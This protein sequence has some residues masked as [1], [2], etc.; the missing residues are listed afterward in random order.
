VYRF[1]HSIGKTPGLRVRGDRTVGSPTFFIY[2]NNG[3]K[4][5]KERIMTQKK[6]LLGPALVLTA[7]IVFAGCLGK[8]SDNEKDFKVRPIEGGKGVEITEYVGDKFEVRIPPR[9]QKLP[10]TSIGDKAFADKSITSVTIPSSVK[11]IG[12]EAFYRCT[13]L[14][15][16][17]IPNGVTS[18]GVMAFAL[19]S[20][21]NITIPD[22]VT[23]MGGSAFRSCSSLTNAII[24]NGIT[25]IDN[26]EYNH[27][28]NWG[29]FEYCKSLTSVTIGNSVNSIGYKAFSGTSLT[30]VIIPS[31]VTSIE[32]EAF[33]CGTLTSVT[34]LGTIP[35]SGFFS[36]YVD[37]SRAYFD[38]NNKLQNPVYRAF[39]GD[40]RAKFYA[41]NKTNGTP[42]TYIRNNNWPNYTWT[43]K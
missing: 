28:N 39:T 38:E 17:I 16:I 40:L 35:S 15:S 5:C 23:N 26:Y 31:S 30:S 14:S 13:G 9:I 6:W 21:T 4:H 43:K 22:S 19:S 29:A 37:S 10:V 41:T 2:P 25:S 7:A 42:G 34:F 20:L 1:S 33:S 24:G 36:D 27:L 3:K 8:K 12:D 11:N 18:I 32:R